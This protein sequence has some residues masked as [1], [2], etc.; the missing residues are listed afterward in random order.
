MIPNLLIHPG[1]IPKITYTQS[2]SKNSLAIIHSFYKICRLVVGMVG[3]SQSKTQALIQTII[4]VYFV[5]VWV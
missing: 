3:P 2:N 4:E 5:K 1:S